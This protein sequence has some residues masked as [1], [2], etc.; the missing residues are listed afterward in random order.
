MWDSL[1]VKLEER[2]DESFVQ[3]ITQRM[4]FVLILVKKMQKHIFVCLNLFVFSCIVYI[5][6][7]I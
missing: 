6:S 7:I 2:E 1:F 4:I 3:H 5:F